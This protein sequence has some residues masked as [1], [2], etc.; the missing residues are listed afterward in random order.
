MN[1]LRDG[2]CVDASSYVIEHNAG[3]AVEAFELADWRRLEDVE[4]PEEQE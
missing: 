4:E 2:E 1:Q 3:A